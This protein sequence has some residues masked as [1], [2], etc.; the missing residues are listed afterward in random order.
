MIG[1]TR[2]HMDLDCLLGVYEHEKHEKQR[3]HV[4]LS[5]KSDFTKA[6]SSDQLEDTLDY[7]KLRFLCQKVADFRHYQLVESLA[8]TLLESVYETFSPIAVK[9][10]V[11][12]RAAHAS[13]ELCKG[14]M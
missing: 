6:C 3:V 14:E 5:V 9:I 4:E 7:D 10:R 2:L 11:T 1:M 13:I 12:K 8:Y